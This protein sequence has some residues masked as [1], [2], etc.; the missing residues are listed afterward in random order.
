MKLTTAIRKQLDEGPQNGARVVVVSCYGGPGLLLCAIGKHDT[1]MVTRDVDD[2][3][4]VYWETCIRCGR[5]LS[6]VRFEGENQ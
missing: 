6:T 3:T 4:A 1:F 2:D 5:V